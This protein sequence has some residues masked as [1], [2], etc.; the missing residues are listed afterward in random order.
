MELGTGGFL[1]ELWAR[2]DRRFFLTFASLWPN[3]IR[4]RYPG[5]A[6]DS[7]A[8]CYLPLLEETGYMPS[9][10]CECWVSSIGCTI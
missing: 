5:A 4:N 9:A 1:G 2:L 7:E 3:S 6:C 8:Y 10:K